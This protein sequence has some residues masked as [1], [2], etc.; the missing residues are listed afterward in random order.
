MNSHQLTD[1]LATVL[2]SSA[3]EGTA[4]ST[5]WW[6]NRSRIKNYSSDS[7]TCDRSF[8]RKTNRRLSV[9]GKEGLKIQAEMNQLSFFT[10]CV[11]ADFLQLML[12]GSLVCN[13]VH[14]EQAPEFNKCSRACST[15]DSVEFWS[16]ECFADDFMCLMHKNKPT[17]LRAAVTAANSHKPSS[18]VKE[19][20]K[21]KTTI[22]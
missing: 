15:T 12:R 20:V 6:R 14:Q 2:F 7:L 3:D 8:D 19:S 13:V 9:V 16:W 5:S 11:S 18:S 10:S 4:P 17:R 22:C 1:C 21:S